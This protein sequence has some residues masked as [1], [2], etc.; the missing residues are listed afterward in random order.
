MN[1][2]YKLI[3]IL[4]IFIIGCK[5]NIIEENKLIQKINSLDMNI[6]SK[7]GNKLYSISSPYSS[8][9]NNKQLFQLKKTKITIFKGEQT[10]YIIYS[11][12]S[13]LSDNNKVLELKGNVKLKTIKKDEDILLGDNFIWDIEKTNY[14]LKGNVRFENKNIILTSQKALLEKIILLN[15][16]IQ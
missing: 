13:T 1:K 6:F 11:D 12:A 5:T 10:K 16:L 7:G 9:D 2:I 3:F 15:F 14:F 4:P 8:Y